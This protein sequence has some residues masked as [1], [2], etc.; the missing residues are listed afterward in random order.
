M[1]IE[2]YEQALERHDWFY[3][4]SDDGRV[5]RAGREAAIKL[6]N[7]AASGTDEFK[8]A[9]NKAYAKRFHREP[10]APPYHFPFQDVVQ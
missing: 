2:E 4:M 3:H 6:K 7:I 8:K 9:F 1:N 5:Y 10:F